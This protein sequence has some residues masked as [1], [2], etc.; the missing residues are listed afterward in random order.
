MPKMTSNRLLFSALALTLGFF[1]MGASGAQWNSDYGNALATAKASN[2]YVLLD[3][4]GS[5]WCPPCL[6][7]KKAVF[8]NAAFLSYAEKHLVLVEIDFP[9][10]KV[11]PP[12]IVKQNERLEKQYNIDGYPAVILLDPNGKSLGRLDGYNGENAAD[13]IAW[14][15]KLGKK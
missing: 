9:R 1:A 11:L 13:V 7:L 10:R 3:F 4:T 6:Q 15:E 14:I 2:K 12:K 8:S 5:D